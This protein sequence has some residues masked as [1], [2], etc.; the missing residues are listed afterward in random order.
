MRTPLTNAKTGA[1]GEPDAAA[2]LALSA[3]AWVLSDDDR[4][5]R[6]LTL[7]GL[8]PGD[9]R[10]RLGEPAVLAAVLTY[11]ESYEPDLVACADDLGTRP[12]TLVAARATLEHA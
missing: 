3:L 8:A 10:E 11:L 12:D 1:M 4:A 9:L 6:L 2:A 5:G 7:T